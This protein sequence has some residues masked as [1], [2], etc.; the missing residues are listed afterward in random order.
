MGVTYN[1]PSFRFRGE[2][3]RNLNRYC[4]V[5]RL[6][7]QIE[8][9]Q[10]DLKLTSNTEDISKLLQKA[11]FEVN[12]SSILGSHLYFLEYTSMS[13]TI[14]ASEVLKCV[15]RFQAILEIFDLAVEEIWDTIQRHIDG[16]PHS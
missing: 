13:Q 9:F 11:D 10:F 7:G 4:G 15:R 6:H 1:F 8:V 5:Y 12:S 14:K 16:F 3:R 2:F